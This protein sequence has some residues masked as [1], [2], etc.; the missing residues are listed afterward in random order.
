M[1]S[2]GQHTF[3]PIT[4]DWI[5]IETWGRCLSVRFVKTHLLIC[6]LTYL[7]QS[8]TLTLADLRSKLPSDVSGVTRY[9][10]RFTLTRERR[11]WQIQRPVSNSKEVI[12]EKLDEID[13]PGKRNIFCL[14]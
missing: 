9:M 10:S 14:T 1:T 2:E 5:E 7:G 12:D 13:V 4:F 6:H 8:V 3:S 11:W